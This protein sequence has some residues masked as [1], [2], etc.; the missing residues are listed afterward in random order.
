MIFFNLASRQ[1]MTDRDSPLFRPPGRTAAPKRQRR[2]SAASTA[3][4]INDIPT[5]I[6][7]TAGMLE[8]RFGNRNGTG[9]A[10]NPAAG[11]FHDMV[12]RHRY[13]PYKARRA[14]VHWRQFESTETAG[15]PAWVFYFGSESRPAIRILAALG[16][17]TGFQ[18]GQ[19]RWRLFV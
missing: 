1:R 18:R 17:A 6:S 10:R 13:L 11:L 14:G 12:A 15:W 2:S 4:G 19:Y 3:M 8:N 7:W 16:K 9:S 5:P